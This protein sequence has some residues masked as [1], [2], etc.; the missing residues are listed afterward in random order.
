MSYADEIANGEACGG[1]LGVFEEENG[2]PALCQEC[3]KADAKPH[4]NQGWQGDGGMNLDGFQPSIYP[5]AAP[6][7]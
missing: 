4:N 3:W 6:P 1:C 5:P 7:G 2:F